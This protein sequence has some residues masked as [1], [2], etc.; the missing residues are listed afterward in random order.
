V[1]AQ[2]KTDHPAVL[3]K[4]ALNRALLARQLLLRRTQSS[5]LTVIEHLV[6][7]QA[8][9][10]DPPYF[11]LWSRMKGFRQ[12]E[13]ADL[14]TNKRVVRIAVLRGTVHL[15]SARD[16]A[17]LR[18]WVQPSMDRA[19]R[20]AWGKELGGLDLDAL[21]AA[22]RELLDE[23]P[24]PVGDLGQ[25]LSERWPQHGPSVLVNALRALLP[26]VQVPPRG[27]WGASAQPTYATAQSWL[28][29][30]LDPAPSAAAIVLRYLAA[31]GPATVKDIQ[32]WSGQ[33][34][35]RQVAEELKPQLLTF[36]DSNGNELLDVPEAPRPGPR[37]S[38]PVR[39][40]APY[41]NLL[42]GHA[43]R[44]RVIS[45]EHRQAIATKNAVMPGTILVDGFMRG[46]WKLDTE[47][48]TATLLI[49]ALAPLTQRHR[50]ALEAEGSRLLAFAADP[51]LA[52]NVRFAAAS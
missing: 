25:K 42:L 17:A 24:W 37:T 14:L 49:R 40:L 48:S 34:R 11:G 19:L 32:A 35:L 26:L 20:T 22:G 52:H 30:D 6:G 4:R 44:T 5:A 18:P 27:I 10:P 21:A 1:T 46:T 13:L 47:R 31:F 33:T 39:F 9:S 45:D 50:A 28:G 38:A 36:R 7:L 15:V 16:C 23:R 12:D 41:D 29:C 8:Q 2:D 51:D 3:S 43:D